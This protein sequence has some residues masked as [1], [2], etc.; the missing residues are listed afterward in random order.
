[1]R[2][3]IIFLIRKRF[4]L[5][6]LERFRFTN[7]YNWNTCYYFTSHSIMKELPHTVKK[8][9]VSLNWLLDPEC[10]IE[11]VPEDDKWVSI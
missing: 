5:K 1:M 2:R 4:G 10:E 11:K 7:Q 3:L 8:S 6:K 9:S